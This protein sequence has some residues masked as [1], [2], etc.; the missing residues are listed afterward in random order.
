MKEIGNHIIKSNPSNLDNV[1]SNRMERLKVMSIIFLNLLFEIVKIPI[2]KNNT[3][4]NGYLKRLR[5][6]LIGSGCNPK[7]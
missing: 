6:P 7:K 1:E 3:A 5:F 4:K 2:T